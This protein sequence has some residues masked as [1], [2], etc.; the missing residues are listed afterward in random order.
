[1]NEAIAEMISHNDYE[2]VLLGE[3]LAAWSKDY[4]V[5]LWVLR[6]SLDEADAGIEAFARHVMTEADMGHK[7]PY[8]DYQE[9]LVG[10]LVRFCR[11]AR[12]AA[13]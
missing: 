13:A 12:T 11:L 8:F 4:S 5:R 7:L 10:F 1:M 6:F 2:V 9:D 3:H